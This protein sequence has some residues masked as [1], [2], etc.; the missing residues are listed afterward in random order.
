MSKACDPVVPGTIGQMARAIAAPAETP[1]PVWFAPLFVAPFIGSFLGVLIRRLPAGRPVVLGRS[2]CE[3]CGRVLAVRDLVPLMSYAALRGRCRMCG[4]R[5]G[6]GHIWIEI[7]AL[8][9]ALG[10]IS[11]QSGI[12]RIWAGCVLGW[13]LLALAWIDW[14]HMRLPDVLTLHLIVLGLLAGMVMDPDLVT[15]RA[16]AAA[17]GYLGFRAIGEGYRLLR[18]REGLGRGDAK[19]LAAAGAWVGLYRLPDVLLAGA[20]LGLGVVLVQAVRL[21]RLRAD[22]L[23]PF[24]PALA[25]ATWAVWLIGP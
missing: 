4:V 20:L 22:M 14:E 21:G 15:D 18:G 11:T 17:A 13:I 19:L 25:L 3:A 10:S 24:G 23:I 7:A 1:V 9:V 12:A 2:A 8:A 5:I 16:I 6:A